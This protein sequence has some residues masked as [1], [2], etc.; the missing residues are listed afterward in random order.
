MY[1]RVENNEIIENGIGK[2]KLKNVSFPEN[3]S[4]ATYADHGFFKEVYEP[5]P[6]FDDLL[7][8]FDRYDQSIV[9]QTVVFSPVLRDRN[10]PDLYKIR[11]ERE[12][13]PLQNIIVSLWERVVENRPGVSDDLQ[14]QREAVKAKHPKP[15][16]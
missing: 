5:L 3:C 9:D 15:E 10:L 14:A 12:Y 7:K 4:D 11:R 13:P 8:E 6:D 2:P 16:A 1:S